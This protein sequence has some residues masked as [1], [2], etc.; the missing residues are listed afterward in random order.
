MFW[1]QQVEMLPRIDM[2]AWQQEKLNQL[3]ERVYEKNSLY[4]KRM[5]ELG[6]GPT[7]INTM[8]DVRKLPFT[9]RQDLVDNYPY[10]LLLMPVSGTSYIHQGDESFDLPT[11][12]SYTR[13]DMAMWSEVMSRILVA[14]GINLTSVFQVAVGSKRYPH[15]LGVHYGA[16]QAGA[17]VVPADGDHPVQQIE[18]MKKFGVTGMFSTQEYLLELFR[19]IS[20]LGKVAQEL[21]L[22]VIFSDMNPKK[23]DRTCYIQKEY[24]VPVLEIYGLNDVF[25]MGIG[26]ECYVQDGLH[27]QEDCF[28]PEII[29]PTSGQVLPVGQVGEFVL[30]SLILEAMPLVRYRT[31]IMGHLDDHPCKCGRTLVRFKK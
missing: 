25:G 15:C 28:Y 2:V 29:E 10:G 30:T 24:G 13:N 21:P 12:M 23:L 5:D 7:D 9:T 19:Q 8:A 6:V 11:A 16:R 4:N 18:L 3:I 1:N 20:Q 17:T 31:G 26:A 14:G 27:I 22:Q